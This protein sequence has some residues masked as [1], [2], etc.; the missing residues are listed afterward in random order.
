MKNEILIPLELSRKA[1]G[2]LSGWSY[3]KIDLDLGLGPHMNDSV[4]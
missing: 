4:E 3:I 2:A 1:L